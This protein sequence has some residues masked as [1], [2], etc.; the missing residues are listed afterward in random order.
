MVYIWACIFSAFFTNQYIMVAPGKWGY[1]GVWVGIAAAAIIFGYLLLAHKKKLLIKC[2]LIL[3]SFCATLLVVSRF[4]FSWQDD[5]SLFAANVILGFSTLTILVLAFLG[6][7]NETYAGI[8][9]IVTIA[10]IILI[11]ICY[12]IITQLSHPS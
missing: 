3:P 7:K 2:E 8:S 5:T 1:I 10:I 12:F 11:Y 4:F 9:Q 6:I